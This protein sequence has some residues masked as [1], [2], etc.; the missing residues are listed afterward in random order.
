M[1]KS[2][3]I[4]RWISILPEDILNIEEIKLIAEESKNLEN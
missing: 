4:N 2:D 3:W 1:P